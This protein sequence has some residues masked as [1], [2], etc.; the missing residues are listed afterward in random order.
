[1][2]NMYNSNAEYSN[3]SLSDVNDLT[4]KSSNTKRNGIKTKTLLSNLKMFDYHG[5]LCK[6][7]KNLDSDS[8]FRNSHYLS[9]HSPFNSLN[10][11]IELSIFQNAITFFLISKFILFC[12]FFVCLK[13]VEILFFGSSKW[14]PSCSVAFDGHFN[15]RNRYN[16]VLSCNKEK[17]RQ[18]EQFKSILLFFSYSATPKG[19][20]G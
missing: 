18:L 4:F 12:F 2:R 5:S 9:I 14:N 6:F 16:T 7:Y 10:P 3:F 20:T 1:M 13:C 17:K 19:K 15:R 11:S 8:V